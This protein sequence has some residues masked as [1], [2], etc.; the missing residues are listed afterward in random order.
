MADCGRATPK[1]PPS[2]ALPL[3]LRRRRFL[4]FRS[5]QIS[6]SAA[7]M[8]SSRCSTSKTPT[9]ATSPGS[10]AGKCSTNPPASYTTNIATP[11]ANASPPRHI[12]SVL[13]KNFLLFTWKNIHS[14]QRLA[15]HFFFSFAGA[16]VTGGLGHSPTRTSAPG[17]LRAFR[18]LPAA[19]RSRWSARCPRRRRRQR[20][21]P[22]PSARV[23]PRPLL[24]ARPRPGAP[25][26]TLR[27]A[28]SH[29][30]AHARR[31]AVHVFHAA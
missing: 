1:I 21:L 17:I 7:S 8:L 19:L 14:W 15:G 6:D 23:F 26:R 30:P 28:V 27:V 4:C 20:S 22:P 11:S 12:Q 3:L 25:P 24:A 18:Q 9:S 5:P 16:V 29:L 2:T 10:A 31:R 13:Q